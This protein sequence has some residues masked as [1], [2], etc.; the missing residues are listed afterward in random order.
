MACARVQPCRAARAWFCGR[1]G[2]RERRRA[3]PSHPATRRLAFVAG[4]FLGHIDAT[5][6]GCVLGLARADDLRFRGARRLV[7]VPTA[8]TTPLGA[9]RAARI[10]LPDDPPPETHAQESR[11]IGVAFTRWGRCSATATRGLVSRVR[12]GPVWAS[13]G[14]T[15]GLPRIFLSR[16]SILWAS[17]HSPT[18]LRRLD[19]QRTVATAAG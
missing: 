14:L 17:L 3:R 12:H 7:A 19:G 10:E 4:P 9:H 15:N 5:A 2:R 8:R 11:R 16:S 6:C 13:I 1:W 18:Q